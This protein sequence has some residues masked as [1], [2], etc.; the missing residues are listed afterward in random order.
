MRQEL[1]RAID[2]APQEEIVAMSRRVQCGSSTGFRMENHSFTIS[3]LIDPRSPWP[4]GVRLNYLA[5]ALRLGS[6]RETTSA[7]PAPGTPHAP[8]DMLEFG[9][10]ACGARECLGPGNAAVTACAHQ[11]QD[12]LA[13]P[14]GQALDRWRFA[15]RHHPAI[16][17]MRNSRCPSSV[18]G[19]RLL[20]GIASTRQ[21]V[22]AT[23]TR[24]HA[25]PLK[26][27]TSC[28]SGFGLCRRTTSVPL[29]GSALS[30]I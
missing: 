21:F 6:D 14:V 20:Y 17:T 24:G 13:K 25:A 26:E 4:G 12:P 8:D 19:S 9:V 2:D 7:F 29:S 23:E 16:V 22:R 1:L 5:V 28:Y 18:V 15:R 10:P 11:D 3:R 30:V 27:T